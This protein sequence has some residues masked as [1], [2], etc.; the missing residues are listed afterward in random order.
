MMKVI[1]MYEYVCLGCGRKFYSA[2]EY[3][4]MEGSKKCDICG[5]Y[6][7]YSVEE[8]QEHFDDKEWLKR[9]YNELEKIIKGDKLDD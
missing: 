1:K 3:S 2:T 6:I 4:M 8:L 5:D 9:E 7:F